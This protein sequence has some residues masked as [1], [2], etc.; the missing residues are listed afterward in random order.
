[1]PS[2]SLEC[3]RPQSCLT[4]TLHHLTLGTPD[5]AGLGDFYA[6]ALGYDVSA[7]DGLVVA[8]AAE[9]HLGFTRGDGSTLAGAGYALPDADEL[10][11]LRRRIA[12]A[13]WSAEEGATA[14]FSDA[15]TLRDPDGTRLSFGIPHD[16]FA[17][18]ATGGAL[19]ARLQHVV[20]ASRDPARTVRFFTEVLGFTLS[21]DVVDGD[22]GVRTSFLRCSH[23]HHSFAVFKAAEDRLDHHCYETTDWNMIRDWSDH[24]ARE[25]IALEWGPGRH[26]PGN[27]LFVFIHD[28]DGNWVELSAELE[29]VAHDRAAGRWPHEERTLNSWGKG[30]LRS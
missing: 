17:S 24:M 20:V 22:G 28:P 2:L 19:A 26:G 9:R 21:D 27:N 29:I 14:F 5:P 4:A 7:R 8:R 16:E 25:H 11:R 18:G 6:R 1:M 15:V 12:A 23:E 30:K 3:H 10:D 13:G